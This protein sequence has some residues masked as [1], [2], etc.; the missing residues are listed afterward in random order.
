MH[1]SQTVLAFDFLDPWCWIAK[2]RLAVAME[3]AGKTFEVEFQP[4][5]S[6][7]TKAS[8]GLSYRAFLELRYGTETASHQSLVTDELR[9]H[10]IKAA[11]D[12]ISAV[13]DILPAVGVILWLQ[14]HG[15]SADMFVERVCEAFYCQGADIGEPMFLTRLLE[16]DGEPSDLIEAFIRDE[17]FCTLLNQNEAEVTKWAGR[18]IPS[19]RIGG[20]VVFGAQTPGVLL[21]L[22]L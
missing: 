1:T 16:S 18:L 9:K 2:R 7:V 21:P 22:L 12:R 4:C 13:P 5:R 6:L 15:R 14:C 20:S 11:I 17:R 19:L 3:Q 10:G 8:I